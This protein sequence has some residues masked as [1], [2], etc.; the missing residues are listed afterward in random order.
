MGCVLVATF[1][2]PIGHSMEGFVLKHVVYW[3][4]PQYGTPNLKIERQV[5]N[6]RT[7]QA[8]G[9]SD[10]NFYEVPIKHAATESPAPAD[11]QNVAP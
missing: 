7:G 2:Q 10:W 11:H 5:V 1:E 4:Q 9:S 6:G 8:M 3:C